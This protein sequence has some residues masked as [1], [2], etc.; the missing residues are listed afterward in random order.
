MQ[1]LDLN[2]SSSQVLLSGNQLCVLSFFKLVPDSLAGITM[3]H[4]CLIPLIFSPQSLY[5]L[6]QVSSWCEESQTAWL[7]RCVLIVESINT[8][9][10]GYQ[11]VS[12]NNGHYIWQPGPKIKCTLFLYIQNLYPHELNVFLWRNPFWT[13]MSGLRVAWK[14]LKEISW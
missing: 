5:S 1:N 6:E 2:W 14:R 8:V 3:I 13:H 12:L 7:P 4:L 10:K 11:E 9:D